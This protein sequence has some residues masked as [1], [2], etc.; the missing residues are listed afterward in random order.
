M[1]VLS[2]DLDGTLVDRDF[3]DN[4]WLIELPTAYARQNNVTVEE[5]RAHFRAEYSKVG[6]NRL[7]WYDVA[8]W[9]AHLKLDA[10]PKEVVEGLRHKVK[11]YPDVLPELRRLRKMGCRMVVFSNAPRLFLDIKIKAEGLDS[12]FERVVSVPSDF[13]KVK[14]HEGAFHQLAKELGV[15]PAE[16]THI[17]DSFEL[18]Y[19]PALA[20]GCKAIL[21]ERPDVKPEKRAPDNSGVRKIRSFEELEELL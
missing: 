12:F 14:S 19:K 18:D 4:L 3:D 15:K 21:I 7:E 9:F 16:I 17:G 11:L 8:Y 1:Q 6:P 20:E 2:F 10:D 5:A 13:K